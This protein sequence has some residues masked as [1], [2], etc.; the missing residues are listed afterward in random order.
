MDRDDFRERYSKDRP[1]PAPGPAS[2]PLS[3]PRDWSGLRPP[4]KGVYA[5]WQAAER[6]GAPYA[7][8]LAPERHALV[9]ALR[10]VR[11]TTSATCLRMRGEAEAAKIREILPNHPGEGGGYQI[12]TD[13]VAWAL[14]ALHDD[15]VIS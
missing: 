5:A 4:L 2:E 15:G 13:L 11:P 12:P 7:F 9:D 10:K 14:K 8:V 6:H 1:A 3:A